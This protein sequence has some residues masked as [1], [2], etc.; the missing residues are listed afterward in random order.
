MS[1]RKSLIALLVAGT[2]LAAATADSHAQ[3]KPKGKKATPACGLGYLPLSEGATWTY[4]TVNQPPGIKPAPIT[5]KVAAVTTEGK[6]TSITLE[7]SYRG[8]T[9]TTVAVC[10]ADGITFPPDSFFFAGEPGG[11]MLM[12]LSDVTRSGD[13]S[14]PGKKGLVAGEQRFEQVKA[15]AARSAVEGTGAVHEPASFTVEK[16]T[17]I[18]AR[19]PVETGLGPYR[20]VRV[21]FEFRGRAAITPDT[22]EAKEQEIQVRTEGAFWFADGLGLVRAREISGREWQLVSSSLLGE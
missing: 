6:Q 5:V 21:S 7:E 17:T 8:T 20:A 16:L 1:S 10:D 14:L 13:P 11:A 3:R 2:A 4:E 22:P 19:E 12:E 15:K 9:T 18:A